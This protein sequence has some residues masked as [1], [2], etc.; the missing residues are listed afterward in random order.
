MSHQDNELRATHIKLGELGEDL[1]FVIR[2]MQNPNAQ[3]DPDTYFGSNWA[4]LGGADNGGVHTN[5]GVQ[6]FWYYLLR[7]YKSGSI[8]EVF[9]HSHF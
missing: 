8:V 4:P 9:W 7:I 3:G 2:N 1:G 5:S 6:N